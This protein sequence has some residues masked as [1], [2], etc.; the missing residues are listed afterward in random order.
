MFDGIS[1]DIDSK[2]RNVLNIKIRDKLEKLNT[3]VTEELLGNY[4]QGQIVSESVTVNQNRNSLKPLV[5]GEVHNISPILA[6]STQLE[7]MVNN[8]PVESIIEVLD[9]GVP[10]SFTTIQQSGTPTACWK[11]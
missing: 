2:S 4:F 5:F 3:P 6:D 7:F 11:F 8:G 10:V 1:T 9:N